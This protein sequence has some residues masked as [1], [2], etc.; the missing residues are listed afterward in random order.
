[1]T[2]S[3]QTLQAGDRIALTAKFLKSTGQQTGPAG[4]RRGTFIKYDDDKFARVHWDDTPAQI[5][6]RQGYFE[7]QDYCDEIARNGSPVFAGNIC[8]VNSP[9]FA[10]NDM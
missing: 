1:M 6:A 7:D 2:K 4:A 3:N 8:K 10:L 5:A 9:R